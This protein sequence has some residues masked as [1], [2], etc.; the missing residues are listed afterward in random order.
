MH[1]TGARESSEIQLPGF[2]FLVC[3]NQALGFDKCFNNYIL[4]M[5]RQ[6][7]NPTNALCLFKNIKAF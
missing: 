3:Q 7:R 2:A 1:F 4:K 5:L 6:L